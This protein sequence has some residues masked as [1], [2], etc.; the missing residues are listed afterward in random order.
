MWKVKIIGILISTNVFFI[1][2]GTS[3]KRLGFE[4][5]NQIYRIEKRGSFN[6]RI[7]ESSGIETHS[8]SQW[9]FHND[10]GGDAALF[11]FD[12]KGNILDTLQFN[13]I[14]NLDWEDIARDDQGAY[15]IG[16]FGNNMN[17]RKDLKILKYHGSKL[18]EIRFI[19]SDQL[20]FPPESIEMNFDLEAMFW[21][22]DS[23]YLFSKNRG[24]KWVKAYSIPDIPGEYELSPIDSIYLPHAITG[25]DINE[26]KTEFA[27]LTYGMVYT[28]TWKNLKSAGIFDSPKYARKFARGG[29]SEAIVYLNETDLLISNE[30]GK[31]YQMKTRKKRKLKP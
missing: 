10:S 3:V 16:E 28:F 23:L 25:A 2:L 29:Q 13:S 7:T 1:N 6:P 8:E 12:P 31:L 22:N 20:S 26:N 4:K 15:Y 24:N 17:T 30:W 9:V 18:E 5:G 19:F 14:R 27:L 11:Y 21:A